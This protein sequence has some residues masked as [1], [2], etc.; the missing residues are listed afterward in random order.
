GKVNH[1]S[2]KEGLSGAIVQTLYE[3]RDGNVWVGTRSGLDRFRRAMISRV[4]SV[5]GL[6]GDVVTAVLAR[7]NGAIEVGTATAGLNQIYTQGQRRIEIVRGLPSGS[8][9]SLYDEPNGRL[10]VGTTAGLVV[11]KHG[12]FVQIRP[13]TGFALDRVTAITG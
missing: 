2:K 3:D 12:R 6:S 9:L 5:E 7:R 10:W 13:P 1:I 4:S 8:I 11:W